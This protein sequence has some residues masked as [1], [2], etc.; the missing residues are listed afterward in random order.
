[1]Q[2][3][4]MIQEIIPLKWFM[5]QEYDSY[6]IPLHLRRVQF[7]QNQLI[8]V[9]N[10]AM[11]KKKK[12]LIVDKKNI[13]ANV[14]WHIPLEILHE[15][16]IAILRWGTISWQLIE[17]NMKKIK[18]VFITTQPIQDYDIMTYESMKE[19]SSRE[20]LSKEKKI[21]LLKKIQ[22]SWKQFRY[23]KLWYNKKEYRSQPKTIISIDDDE[24]IHGSIKW[25][26]Y[27]FRT[28]KIDKIWHIES[29]HEDKDE[30]VLNRYDELA[31][32]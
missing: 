10:L 1:M 30:N 29:W 6:H 7:S 25:H 18:W 3:D 17:K 19:L 2:Y 5:K 13:I 8:E 15:K 20:I 27:M 24:I 21:A 22:K 31:A 9:L 14:S 26:N 28:L 11:K 12:V 4:W 16:N 32:K 23:M